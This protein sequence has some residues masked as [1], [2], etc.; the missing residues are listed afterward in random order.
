M[1]FEINSYDPCVANQMVDGAQM[2]IYWH[3][4]NL[5]IF[6]RDEEMVDAFAI[7]MAEMFGP[8]TTISR[9]KVH[10]YLGM[11]LYFGTNPGTMII[12]TIKY[13]QKI[14]DGFPKVLRGTKL[15]PMGDQLFKIQQEEDREILPEELSK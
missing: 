7:N 8:K 15:C 4:E 11:E 12:S 3:A 2:T 5:N 10:D 6:H 9:G 14:M 1:G 13:L